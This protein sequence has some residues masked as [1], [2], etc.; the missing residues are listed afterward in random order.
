MESVLTLLETRVLALERDVEAWARQA[1]DP[2]ADRVLAVLDRRLALTQ[3]E[4]DDA[5]LRARDGRP[6]LCRHTYHHDGTTCIE[7][8][9]HLGDHSNGTESWND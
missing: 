6:Q 7:D 4:L 8:E 3:L 9:G 5:R 1:G 2:R